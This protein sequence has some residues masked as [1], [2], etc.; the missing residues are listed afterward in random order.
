MTQE[1]RI[2]KAALCVEV[3]GHSSEMAAHYSGTEPRILD[4]VPSGEGIEGKRERIFIKDT[5]PSTCT[6]EDKVFR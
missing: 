4:A 5:T 3:M 2:L 1:Q 6:T